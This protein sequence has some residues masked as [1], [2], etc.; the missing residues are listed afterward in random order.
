M[1]FN[2]LKDKK[3]KADYA[4]TRA[5]ANMYMGRSLVTD[6]LLSQAVD[7]YKA[8]GDTASH[9]E[10]VIAQANHLRSLERKDEA[11]ALIDSLVNDMPCDI[12]RQLNQVLLGFSFSDKDNAK[13]LMIIDRQIKLAHDG[14]E[15]LNFEIKKI[16]PLV[17]LNRSKDAV[18]LCDSLFALPDAPEEG[19]ND[20]L[21]M[22]INYAAALG[23]HRETSPQAVAILKDVLGRM[24]NV[25]SDKLVEF[26]IPMVNLQLNSGNINEATK[27]TNLVDSLD[28]D[29]FDR[30]PV[31]ASYLEFLKIVLDYEHNGALS[32][33]RLSNTAHSLRKVSNDLEVKRQERDD[34]LENAYDLSRSNYELTIRH[35][36]LWLFIILIMLVGVII[37][38]II[39]FVAHRRRQ[40]LIEAEERIEALEQLAMAA[41]KPSPDDKQ[42]L[43]KKTLLLQIDIIRAFAEAPTAHNQEALKKISNAGNS[44]SETDALVNWSELYPVI[45]ELYDKFHANLLNDYPGVLSEREIQ[46]LCLLRAGFSTKEIGV[47]I[48]QTSNSVYVSK[49]SIRKKLGLLPKEDFIAFL[50]TRKPSSGKA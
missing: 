34:A 41:T 25:P 47:L 29:I 14:S 45:D 49:T 26:Y 21:Y 35:Q 27:Y 11:W 36:H 44:D 32:L 37:V 38:T 43:L 7:F 4:L 20:W 40:K 24:K 33:S 16:T 42:A 23:E 30:Y 28:S 10:S 17:T 39:F 9:I 31:A 8:V 48:Q 22:R 15:R 1:D 50:T 2:N 46:I 6:T 3:L 5:K 12:Q 19:S 18:A 13:A